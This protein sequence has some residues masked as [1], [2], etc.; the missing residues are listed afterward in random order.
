MVELTDLQQ[1]DLSAAEAAERLLRQASEALAYVQ[2]P[3]LYRDRRAIDQAAM[4]LENS[5][6]LIREGSRAGLAPQT[7]GQR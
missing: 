7:D 6:A 1:R 4:W 5:M 2:D 3:R